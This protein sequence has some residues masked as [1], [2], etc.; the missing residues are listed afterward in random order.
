MKTMKVRF[1]GNFW[2]FF[3]M[4]L[5]LIVLSVITFGIALPYYVYWQFKYFFTKLE[6]VED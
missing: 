5:G 1:T 6:I 3:L 2:E 4:S